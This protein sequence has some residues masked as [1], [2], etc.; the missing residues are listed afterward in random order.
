MTQTQPPQI[1]PRIWYEDRDGNRY[2]P[3]LAKESGFPDLPGFR[4][5]HHRTPD[6]HHH[7]DVRGIAEE[8]AAC[9]HENTRPTGGWVDGVEGRECLDCESSQTRHFREP[10]PDK[11][12][13]RYRRLTSMQVGWSEDLALAMSRPT[14]KELAT[15]RSRG[16]EPK[17]F[18]LKD[19]ILIGSV[20][21]EACANA[22]AHEYGLSWGYARGSEEWKRARTSCELCRPKVTVS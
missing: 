4:Y 19:A 16:F 20:A 5:Y 8:I 21:C 1:P 22:L 17:L 9:K 3:D 13:A 7:V 10:W 11:W 14:E 18:G 12:E 15:A 2:V 6:L